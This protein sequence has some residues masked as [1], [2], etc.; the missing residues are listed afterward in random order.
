M[1]VALRSWLCGRGFAV[2]AEEV[3][4]LAQRS[5]DAARE[6]NN[7][8]SKNLERVN[9]GNERAEEASKST[10]EIVAAIERVNSIMK[11][12]SNASAEQ[13][14]GVQEV[15]RAVTEMDHV[16][17]NAHSLLHAMQVF[18]LPDT[19]PDAQA[20]RN[21]LAP[22]RAHSTNTMSRLPAVKTQQATPEWESF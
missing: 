17:Q 14:T 11:E 10:V 7:L 12:I 6:I 19:H 9:H 2:V 4:R 22:V 16:R 1:A 18:K 15:G 20:P 21:A 8:I 5:A 13:S 3:R